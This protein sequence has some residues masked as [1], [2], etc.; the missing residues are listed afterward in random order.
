[1]HNT[2]KNCDSVYKDLV[3]C[4]VSRPTPSLRYFSTLIN[5]QCLLNSVGLETSWKASAHVQAYFARNQVVASCV[6]TDVSLG[7]ITREFFH[8]RNNVTCCKTSFPWTGE[9]RN[10]LKCWL[11]KVELLSTFRNNLI[12][13]VS[14]KTHTTRIFNSFC[15][16]VSKQLARFYRPFFPT[17]TLFVGFHLQVADYCD[18][19]PNFNHCHFMEISRKWQ[20][21]TGRGLRD[22][23]LNTDERQIRFSGNPLTKFRK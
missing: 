8:S 2:S 14:G 11:Q 10:L 19:P 16:S 23:T 4:V 12:W 17:F 21:A 15:S 1:M 20:C 18:K 7:K 3:S 6:N 22:R 5:W 9:T 13:I